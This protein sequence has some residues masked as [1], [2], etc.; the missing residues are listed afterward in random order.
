MGQMGAVGQMGGMGQLGSVVAVARGGE[1]PPEEDPGEGT[2]LAWL[3]EWGLEGLVP[4]DQRVRA[5][6]AYQKFRF[7]S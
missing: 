5:Y 2:V 4:E 6:Q 3:G 1:K 7:G